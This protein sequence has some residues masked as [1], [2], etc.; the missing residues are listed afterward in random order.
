MIKDKSI[1]VRLLKLKP[2]NSPSPASYRSEDSFL[3]TQYGKKDKFNKFSAQKIVSYFE[4][5]ADNHKYVPGAGAYKNYEA[6][7]TK[8]SKSPSS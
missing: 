5:H 7:F 8:L 6:A 3:K 4:K 2:D 1:G